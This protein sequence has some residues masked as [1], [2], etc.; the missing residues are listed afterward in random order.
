MLSG[1]ATF[2]YELSVS[3]LTRYLSDSATVPPSFLATPLV[4]RLKTYAVLRF[5]LSIRDPSVQLSPRVGAS[6]L[7]TPHLKFNPLCA[8]FCSVSGLVEQEA[9]S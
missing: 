8:F 1:F 7:L 5:F 9:P 2:N 3:D 6:P 4:Q